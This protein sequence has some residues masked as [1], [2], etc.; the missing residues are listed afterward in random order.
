MPTPRCASCERAAAVVDVSLVCAKPCG[1]L[2]LPQ[3]VSYTARTSDSQREIAGCRVQILSAPYQAPINITTTIL[4]P[5]ENNA[6]LQAYAA[7]NAPG[8]KQIYLRQAG[9]LTHRTDGL[10]VPRT[11]LTA[12]G[13]DP[14]E[15]R[16][17]HLE[18]HF[19]TLMPSIW[20][21]IRQDSMAATMLATRIAALSKSKLVYDADAENY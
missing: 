11:F 9:G 13:T 4:Q 12:A 18:L 20:I 16:L 1:Q 6:Q 5:F 19:S 7:A 15:V 2:S 3:C 14:D 21:S 8:P 17:W 10:P